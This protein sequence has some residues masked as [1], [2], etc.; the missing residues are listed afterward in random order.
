MSK[1]QTTISNDL[2]EGV[3]TYS[4][5][6]RNLTVVAATLF[7]LFFVSLSI[8]HALQLEHRTLERLAH[9]Y[10]ESVLAFRNY[11]TEQ[12]VRRLIDHPEVT[13][14][15]DY[16]DRPHAIPIPATLS[17][18]LLD[19]LSDQD[20]DLAIAQV[21]ESPFPWRAARILSP[22]ESESLRILRETDAEHHTV[23][24]RSAGRKTLHHAMAIRMEATCIACHNSHPDSPRRDWQVGDLRAAQIVSL[25]IGGGAG[26]V[27]RAFADFWQVGL[28]V[29]LA[30]GGGL[31]AL[32]WM[33]RRVR[34]ALQLAHDKAEAHAA[35][36]KEVVDRQHALDQHAIVSMADVAG[37][38]TYVNEK[39][40]AI[41]GYTQ[42]ELLGQNHRMVR[43][44]VHPPEFYEQ[45]WQTIT[46][47][48]VWHGEI[49]NRARDGGHYWVAATIVPFMDGNGLPRQ[50]I[51][52]RTDI[53]ERKRIEQAMARAREEAE[54]ANRAKSEFL[55]SMSHELRT[56]L[57]AILGFSDV[58]AG[59]RF[60]PLSERQREYLDHISRGG[61][62]LLSLIN[63]VLDLARIEAGRISLSLE[64]FSPD[65]VIRECVQL[66]RKL[67]EGR[68]ITLL[69]GSDSPLPPVQADLTRAR[70]I[71]LNLLSNAIKYNRAYG[72]AKV[73][74]ELPGNGY[75]RIAVT[76]TGPGIPEDKQHELFQPF[77]RL[78]QETSQTEGTGIGLTIT[79]RVVEAMGGQ[80]GFSSVEGEGSTFWFELPL[81]DALPAVSSPS[82]ATAPGNAHERLPIPANGR[83]CHVLYVEDNPANRE[84][85]QCV[86]EAAEGG[87]HY[88]LTMVESGEEAIVQAMQEPPD[89]LLLD[90]NLPGMDGFEC[91][92]ALRAL[93]ATAHTPAIAVSANILPEV[94]ARAREVGFT[95]F[96]TKPVGLQTL[97]RAI[98]KALAE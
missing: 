74:T 81:A 61:Q 48:Q 11:Y 60:E 26:I 57:N 78:G 35:A 18:E 49:C 58:L 7:G 16:H 32:F 96:L 70:Q 77:S 8:W 9:S 53:T 71:L 30:F 72:L 64:A 65:D 90:I 73:T 13:I 12:V 66:S 10:S 17:L 95:D 97:Y 4:R 63:E 43:S 94:K 47:G 21:S 39:F 50:Y 91:L 98:N 45:L 87:E 67:A 55:S 84:L 68:G 20:L 88:R 19:Y 46:Q 3:A 62:H 22:I 1:Q 23:I 92:E 54:A 40:C 82:G 15:H 80:I 75:L 56:P 83:L 14:T 2:P 86:F 37:N 69:D 25:P 59:D 38:I 51:S 79:R 34:R 6:F 29:L 42:E 76:D 5:L 89:L 33:D 41:S 36:L 85:M 93:R 52:I 31:T 44:D 27:E 24:E 28:L